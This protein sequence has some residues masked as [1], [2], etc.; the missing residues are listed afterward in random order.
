MSG[1]V[2][3]W[4]SHFILPWIPWK[5][6]VIMARNPLPGFPVSFPRF[7]EGYAIFPGSCL[8]DRYWYWMTHDPTAITIRPG[9]SGNWRRLPGSF[10]LPLWFWIFRSPTGRLWGRWRWIWKISCLA[11]WWSH[12]PIP[13]A[14]RARCCCLPSPAIFRLRNGSQILPGPFGWKSTTGI[15]V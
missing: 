5:W 12:R 8:P 6:R 11:P 1:G 15:C 2:C 4:V 13:A 10:A 7:P 3:P 9:S 14:P